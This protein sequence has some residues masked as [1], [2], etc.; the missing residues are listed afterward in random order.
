MEEGS[1]RVDANVSARLRGE[2]K[3]GTK[4]RSEEHELVLR[5]RARARGGVRAPV[6]RA[7]ERRRRSCSRRCSG[8]PTRGEVRPAAPRKEATTIAI[9]PSPI[10]RRCMLA[11]DVDRRRRR[12]T[13]P[14]CPTARRARFATRV[15]AHAEYDIEVLTADAARR[16]LLRGGRARRTAMP[17]ARG[18]L[19]DGRGARR[20]SRRP[21]ATSRH[22]PRSAR[23]PRAAARHGARGVVSHTAAKQV[24][25]RMVDDRRAAGA[26]RRARGA[27]Q[28]ATTTRSSRGWIDEVIAE[29][30]DEADALSRRRREA[31]GV[32]VGLV[33]KKSKGRADPKTLNQLLVGARSAGE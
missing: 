19:G 2:T 16:R 21:A 26:D 18:Q 30:P 25:A 6:S 27:H 24:F 8:T 22:V 29:N 5:R 13:C 20:G 4:T 3:L 1:L 31:Q 33:M 17:K 23:R 15:R 11:R 28:G 7:R 32:L 9:S 14:S 12:T 10:C